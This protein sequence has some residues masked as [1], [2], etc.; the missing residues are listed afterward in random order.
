MISNDVVYSVLHQSNNITEE[1]LW[2][3]ENNSEMHGI[4]KF[5]LKNILQLKFSRRRGL[6]G[7]SLLAAEV[8][9]TSWLTSSL[10]RFAGDGHTGGQRGRGGAWRSGRW[11]SS[12]AS[13]STQRRSQTDWT[14][15]QNSPEMHQE[16]DD[17]CHH[18]DDHLESQGVHLQQHLE[19][20]EDDKEHICDL[21]ELFQ[22]VRLV[23]VLGGEDPGVE[24][25]Q[26]DD[27]PE[28]GLGLDSPPTVPPWLSVPSEKR[29]V[30]GEAAGPEWQVRNWF[31]SVNSSPDIPWLLKYSQAQL[32]ISTSQWS[33]LLSASRSRLRDP[34]PPRLSS[35]SPPW[36]H[37]P[38]L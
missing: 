16:S 11:G 26:D 27:E 32:D 18:V 28:H 12:R 21:L 9:L 31:R 35:H 6:V 30:R 10:W 1:S 38:W 14:R 15:I 4:E 24:E 25:D 19:G 17:V 22:P 34:P 36:Q 37:S 5:K 20:E 8:L 7:T 13:C 23:V 33:W 29:E 2:A 3:G